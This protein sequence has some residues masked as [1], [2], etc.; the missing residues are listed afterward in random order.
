MRPSDVALAVTAA[1]S[2]MTAAGAAAAAALLLGRTAPY[3]R[4]AASAPAAARWGP[5]IPARLAWC[6]QEAPSLLAPFVFGA[7]RRA[8][9]AAPVARWPRWV[10]FAP[11]TP[12]PPTLALVLLVAFVLH[13]AWRALVYPFIIPGRHPT[14]A[15]VWAMAL[16]F[17]F[18]NGALQGA[19]LAVV[20]ATP[21]THPRVVIGLVL[22]ASGW[23]LNL[24]ADAVLRGLK[25]KTPGYS[26]PPP[27]GPF[28]LVACPNY[29]GE[30]IEWTG[31]ALAAGSPPASAFAFFTAANL[32]PR[33]LAHRAWYV[34]R[35]PRFPRERRAVLPWLL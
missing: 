23:T 27:V 12:P 14:P 9:E 24:W 15:G 31:F 5:P 33:A 18:Y 10:A 29:L 22:W 4:H 26:L 8:V 11:P 13:Y 25:K 30:I 16:G 3:G 7:V 28:A 2:A 32:L 34:E 1:S 35:F 21:L 19:G 20:P 17:C 6:T